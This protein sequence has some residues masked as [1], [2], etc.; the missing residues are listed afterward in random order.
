LTQLL[1][2]KA[3]LVTG[4][5]GGIGRGIAVELAREGATVLVSDLDSSRVGGEETVRLIE[6]EGGQA[7]WQ[8]CDVRDPMQVQALTDRAVREFGRLDYAVNNAGIAVHKPMVEVPEEDYDRIL[9]VN[10]KGVWLGMQAQLRQMAAQGGGAIVNVSSVAGLTAI[11]DI[12]AYVASKHGIN[13]L[14]KSAAMEYGGQGVRVNAVCPNAIRT[15][16]MDASPKEFVDALLAPQ[17]IKRVGEPE[18][19]GFAVA[20]LLSDRAAYITGVALPVDGGYMTGA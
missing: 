1:A 13:G 20:F 5:A 18:E 2:G 14:T 6:T 3:G 16:L 10:L 4:A 9:D 8:S 12:S 15:P 17:S 11:R 7:A 19:V